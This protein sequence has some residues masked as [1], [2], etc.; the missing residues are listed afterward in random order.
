MAAA[1]RVLANALLLACTWGALSGCLCM[2]HA[3]GTETTHDDRDERKIL[4]EGPE[5]PT[6]HRRATAVLEGDALRIGTEQRH[7]RQVRVWVHRVRVS[8]T[9]CTFEGPPSL[10]T[11]G[12]SVPWSVPLGQKCVGA[13]FR[14][15]MLLIFPAIVDCLFFTATDHQSTGDCRRRSRTRSEYEFEETRT[16]ARWHSSPA[17]MTVRVADLAPTALTTDSQGRAVFKLTADHAQE[18]RS[19]RP[20]VIVVKFAESWVGE[21]V[22]L[23]AAPELVLEAV[24]ER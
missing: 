17:S 3:S 11:F 14:M 12:W 24:K 8:T 22:R 1:V 7:E 15:D 6:F 19:G 21:E 9:R 2:I 10:F 5:T 16:E 4:E 18:A 23:V 20:T 13:L